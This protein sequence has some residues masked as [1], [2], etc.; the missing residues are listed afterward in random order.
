M[1]ELL[2]RWKLQ[3]LSAT[4][5]SLCLVNPRRLFMSSCNKVS[6]FF[7]FLFIFIRKIT[8]MQDILSNM[9][10]FDFCSFVPL[11][12]IAEQ[13][14]PCIQA[15]DFGRRPAVR[16]R[17][18]PRR[19]WWQRDFGRRVWR[20]RGNLGRHHEPRTNVALLPP[21]ARRRSF[22]RPQP[23]SKSKPSKVTLPN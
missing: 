8:F 4:R 12:E 16:R 2:Q 7:R 21:A 5:A 22:S 20:G 14:L 6:R 1:R 3:S 19:C 17:S 13:K 15:G 11:F 9:F 23:Y 18:G 10:L